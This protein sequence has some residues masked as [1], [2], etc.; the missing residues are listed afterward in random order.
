MNKPKW[1][2]IGINVSTE[3][4]RQIKAEAKQLGVSVSQFIRSLFMAWLQAK[5]E[6]TKRK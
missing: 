6:K 3:M 4:V 2:F 1:H 5:A